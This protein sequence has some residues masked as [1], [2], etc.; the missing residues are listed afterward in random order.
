MPNVVITMPY[1]EKEA[2]ELMYYGFM[3]QNHPFVIRYP[4]G[5]VESDIAVDKIEFTDIKPTWKILDDGNSVVLISYGPSLDLLKSV[6]KEMKI[7]AKIVN[8]RFIKP[9][10]QEMMHQIAKMKTPILVYEEISNSGSLYPQ[11][12]QFMAKHGYHNPM[13]E[14]SITDQIVEHGFYKDML[15]IHHMDKEDAEAIRN[16]LENRDYG[17]WKELVAAHEVDLPEG[18]KSLLE[19]ID[20]E[21]VFE[22]FADKMG[23]KKEMKE[24]K[25]E[26]RTAIREKLEANDYEGWKVLVAERDGNMENL[27][28]SMLEK[29]DTADKFVKLVKL[30]SLKEEI[31]VL[32]EE[33]GLLNLGVKNGKK[34][35]IRR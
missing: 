12:L 23:E 33:L 19:K 20:S 30:N 6:K 13:Y 11:I 27:K 21:E 35:G 15:K 34:T 7:D 32:N 25:E 9:I 5:V 22:K 2:S 28:F 8:A 1:N 24:N 29:I 26:A 16:A 31:R 4:R 17:T 3:K 14:M 10:D 18:A